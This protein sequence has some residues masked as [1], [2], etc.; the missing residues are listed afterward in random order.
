MRHSSWKIWIANLRRWLRRSLRLGRPDRRPEGSAGIAQ[1]GHREYVGGRWEEIGRLQF[2]FLVEHGL[3]S[4]HV[5]LDVACGSLRAGIHLISYLD[6]RNYWGLEKESDLIDAGLRQELEPTIRL[7]KDPQFLIN[8]QFDVS[9]MRQ[10]ADY[11]LIHSLFTHLP[12]DLIQ[13]CLQQLKT[14]AHPGT[15]CYATFFETAV[16]RLHLDNSHDHESFFYT[17]EEIIN[18]CRISGWSVEYLGDWGHPRGQKMLRLIP[19]AS[20]RA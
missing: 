6:C 7:S 10:S 8:D 17:R 2:D 4:R 20:Q 9:P 13:L 15:V 16:P 18:Y 14:A 1:L 19:G 5:L 11:I 3:L 12:P